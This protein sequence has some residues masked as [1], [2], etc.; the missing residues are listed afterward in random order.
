[1]KRRIVLIVIILSLLLFGCSSEATPDVPPSPAFDHMPLLLIRS[2]FENGYELAGYYELDTN[3]D[4]VEEALAVATLNLP[5]EQAR[6]VESHVIL[7]VEH[8]GAWSLTDHWSVD[9]A[10]ARAELR[11]LT[12]DGLAELLVFTE[13]AESRLG[14]FVAPL[15]YTDHVTVFTY[16]PEPRLLK[17]GSFSSSLAGVMHPRSQV[18]EWEGQ[19]VIQTA[20]DVPPTGGP[21][22]QPYRVETFAWDGQGFTSRQ[23]QEQRRI[24]PVVSWLVRRNGPWAAL[25]LALGGASC[26]AC[27][28]LLFLTRRSRL[29]E[30]WAI[31]G[32]GLLVV[33]GGVGLGLAQEWLCVP[34]LILIGLL[35]LGIGRQTATWMVARRSRDIEGEK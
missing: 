11:D 28:A 33:A 32:L 23:V 14:D 18:V 35:G 7:F 6:L 4:G 29:P 19:P 34:A 30:R 13:E 17:M 16:T 20:Q 15:R 12:G 8:G 31:L 22:W 9:G 5:L 3:G 27:Y 21:L 24:S 1:M 25:F 2:L 26:F 10:N